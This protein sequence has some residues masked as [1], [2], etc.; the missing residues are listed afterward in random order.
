MYGM[1]QNSCWNHK[2]RMHK[3]HISGARNFSTMSIKL[4]CCLLIF[5]FFPSQRCEVRWPWKM[6]NHSALLSWRTEEEIHIFQKKFLD[7]QRKSC[8]FTYPK[9]RKWA[10]SDTLYSFIVIAVVFCNFKNSTQVT[11]IALIYLT[12]MGPCIVNI[13]QYISNK[14]QLYTVYLYLETAVHA[15]QVTV[16]VWQIPD[17]VDTVACAPDDGWRY[18][19][20]HVEQFPDINKLC[21][22]CI[23][24]DIYWNM[25]CTDRYSF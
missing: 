12:F 16:T 4:R 6:F 17:A 1:G 15:L 21:K 13:F 10:S 9:R 22:S 7:K 24:L 11:W 5:R 2:F 23:L 14:M 25:N 3:W 8:P 19:P 20:K 18:H